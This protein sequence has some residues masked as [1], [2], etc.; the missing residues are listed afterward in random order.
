MPEMLP[1]YPERIP[2]FPLYGS[3][4]LPNTILPLNIF[5]TRYRQMVEYTLEQDSLIGMVQP[6]SPEEETL[7]EI[8]CLGKIQHYQKKQN[9]HYMIQLHGEIRFQVVK[10]LETETMFRRAQ[11]DYSRFYSDLEQPRVER[12][13]HLLDRKS[14]V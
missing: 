2:I 11:V 13:L 3:I 7:Q 9:G 5:E 10:E 4:L 1:D 14:V 12:E 6:C 8:G